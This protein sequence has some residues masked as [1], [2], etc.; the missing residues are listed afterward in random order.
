M[1]LSTDNIVSAEKLGGPTP[2]VIYFY[3]SLLFFH[4]LSFPSV[5]SIGFHLWKKGDIGMMADYD[6]ANKAH[7]PLSSLWAI[8]MTTGWLCCRVSTCI[9][10]HLSAEMTPW[11]AVQAECWQQHL[12]FNG[13]SDKRKCHSLLLILLPLCI[14]SMRFAPPPFKI[15]C[16]TESKV[17]GTVSR[18]KHH[19]VTLLMM[20]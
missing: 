18:L 5:V 1:Q 16:G 19:G 13:I 3:P 4:L 7:P 14:K 17:P 8:N 15:R 6:Q 10:Q 9:I 20:F 12:S 11:L 2:K